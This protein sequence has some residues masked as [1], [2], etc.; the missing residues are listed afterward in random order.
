MKTVSTR[1]VALVLVTV[2]LATMLV[3]CSS[4]F[5]KIKE[6]FVEAGYTYV[7]QD[8]EGNE[9]AKTITTEL[10]QGDLDCTVHFFKKP[11]IWKIP[12]YCMV[13]EFKT[14]KELTKA[15]A[16]DNM[17][18]LRGI[19]EDLQGSDLVRDNCILI[20]LAFDINELGFNP[21]EEMIEVFNQ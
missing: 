13:L 19:I 11:V 17:N 14:D 12:V 7:S 21:R 20:P 5:D 2:M 1:I 15:L 8:D 6:N 3:S 10:K 9:T 16:A 4:T 18:T